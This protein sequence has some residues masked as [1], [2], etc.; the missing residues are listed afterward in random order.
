MQPPFWRS[1]ADPSSATRWAALTLTGWAS[2]CTWSPKHGT[3]EASCFALTVSAMVLSSLQNCHWHRNRINQLA[4]GGGG[5]EGCRALSRSS[6][7]VSSVSSW[8]VAR[9][10]G[11]QLPQALTLA[12]HSRADGSEPCD[13]GMLHQRPSVLP[14]PTW[15]ALFSGPARDPLSHQEEGLPAA[16]C[17]S[18]PS[19]QKAR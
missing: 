11:E 7:R 15:R 14:R 1:Q 10:A 3:R 5:G 16:T 18:Q 13:P 2:Q 4:G 12:R 6:P 19:A 17:R 9:S 8:L